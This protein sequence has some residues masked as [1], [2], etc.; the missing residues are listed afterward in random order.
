MSKQKYC[1]IIDQLCDKLGIEDPES[2]Y[3][4][5]N[6]EVDGIA[7]TLTYG[8]YVDEECLLIYSDFGEPP[9]DDHSRAKAFQRLMEINLQVFARCK[10]N[11]GFNPETGRVLM[12]THFGLERAELDLVMFELVNVASMV[13]LWRENF[14][15]A[16]LDRALD[17]YEGMQEPTWPAELCLNS[18]PPTLH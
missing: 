17:S 10:P 11:F 2:M 8:D 13:K 9:M 12:M 16:P 15:V 18:N 1:D 14:F 3:E 4:A 6:L 7:F 5:C